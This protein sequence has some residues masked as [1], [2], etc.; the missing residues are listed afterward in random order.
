[1]YA[2]R[3][4]D[5][6]KVY[7]AYLYK[8]SIREIEGRFYD[9]DEKCWVVPYS[10]KN[11]YTLELLGATLDESLRNA[12]VVMHPVQKDEEPLL[13]PRIKGTLYKH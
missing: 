9:A 7:D 13:H 2:I 4:N 3:S 8:E 11:A 5:L 12:A 6:I 10:I 1:M